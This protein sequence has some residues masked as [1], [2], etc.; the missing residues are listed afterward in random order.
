MAAEL[1]VEQT[2]RDWSLDSVWWPPLLISCDRS[3]VDSLAPHVSS[4]YT[5]EAAIRFIV[6]RARSHAVIEGKK[7]R[8]MPTCQR[9]GAFGNKEDRHINRWTLSARCAESSCWIFHGY[10]R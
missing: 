4:W 5:R 9:R 2:A 6:V 10:S 3:A 7:I 1:S 8:H